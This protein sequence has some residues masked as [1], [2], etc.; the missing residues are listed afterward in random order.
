MVG[1]RGELSESVIWIAAVALP[2]VLVGTWLGHVLAPPV[3]DA[4]LKRSAFWL[5]LVMGIWVGVT[6][7]MSGTLGL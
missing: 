4:A 3:S 1:W 6:A 7:T 5:I 2:V